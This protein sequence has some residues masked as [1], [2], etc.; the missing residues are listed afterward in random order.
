MGVRE[1]KLLLQNEN[2]TLSKLLTALQAEQLVSLEWA[3]GGWR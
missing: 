3:G 1:D 2:K